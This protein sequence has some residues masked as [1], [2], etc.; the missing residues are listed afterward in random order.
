MKGGLMAEESTLRTKITIDPGGDNEAVYDEI[1][2]DTIEIAGRKFRE[3][4]NG[5]KF[6]LIDAS[7]GRLVFPVIYSRYYHRKN[8][9]HIVFNDTEHLLLLGHYDYDDNG[10]KVWHHCL[11][12]PEGKE[13]FSTEF[14]LV[15]A[16][17]IPPDRGLRLM[18]CSVDSDH[19]G[20]YDIDQ[21]KFIIPA[22]Y[23]S[24][25]MSPD[26]NKILCKSLLSQLEYRW[27]IYDLQGE[28]TDWTF[29]NRPPDL[30]LIYRGC[31]VGTYPSSI[32]SHYLHVNE[33]ATMVAVIIG[34]SDFRVKARLF[35]VV[36]IRRYSDKK[37]GMSVNAF[38]VISQLG[39]G[40]DPLNLV[41]ELYI[42]YHR[43]FDREDK[44]I[45]IPL[46]SRAIKWF[47]VDGAARRAAKK[48]RDCIIFV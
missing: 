38:I 47:G 3:V 44:S 14:N 11:A 22:R 34:R 31:F 35:D 1:S 33:T 32:K 23:Y 15:R 27:E 24:I 2:T 45:K 28:S 12:S 41:Y 7:D 10:E 48:Y 30:D 26:K 4:F 16:L 9:E 17:K 42:F 29:T 40:K 36:S 25:N 43:D 19:M 39:L 37:S 5:D 46:S 8:V 13:V 21:R 20:V 6:G 18:V